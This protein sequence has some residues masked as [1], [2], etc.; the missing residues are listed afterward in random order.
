MT[1]CLSLVALLLC[2]APPDDAAL[3]RAGGE[4][5]LRVR[6]VIPHDGLS[7]GERLLNGRPPLQP[8]DRVLAEVVE[9]PGR[10]P[11]LVGGV[12]AGVTPPGRFG[13]P[14]RV[15]LE[16]AQ[17]AAVADDAVSAAP[18]RFDIEDARFSPARRR[19]LL[20]TLFMLEG[21]GAGAAVGAQFDRGRVGAVAGG[22]GVGLILGTAYA[23]CQP[24][25]VASLEPGDTLCV[26]V[27]G[28]CARVLPPE[29]RLAIFPAADPT[30]K[31]GTP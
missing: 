17:F 21:L 24:G 22:A 29:T 11:V 26:T 23:A 27:G 16:L 20:T 14:G 3:L 12:V 15:T 25:R 2:A 6:Q 13:R 31:K 30:P 19:R 18:W 8:G 5:T 9:P 4:V 7:R 1:A 28:V 10:P